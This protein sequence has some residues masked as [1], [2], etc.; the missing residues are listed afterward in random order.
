VI[1]EAG[2]DAVA[3]EATCEN[4]PDDKELEKLIRRVQEE[5]EVSVMADVSTVDEGVRAWGMGA[6][7]VATTLSGYTRE[8]PPREVPDYELVGRL[9]E[10]G[11]RVV[12]EGHVR[13]PEQLGELF[14]RGAY[15]VVVGTAITDPISITSWFVESIREHL[16]WKASGG[17]G[18]L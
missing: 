6:D 13:T 11:V 3:L 9:A 1:V 18:K 7:L 14:K 17:G 2:A 15:A 16:E 4:R 5:L 12:A 8:S 10:E